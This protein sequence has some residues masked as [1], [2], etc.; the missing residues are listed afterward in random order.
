MKLWLQREKGVII[1]SKKLLRIMKK[2]QLLSV[3]RRKNKYQPSGVAH[4]THPN[5]LNRQFETQRKNKKWVTDITYIQTSQGVLYLSAILDLFDRSIVAYQVSSSP[6][7][8]LV[9]QTLQS[10]WVEEK[11]AGELLLHSDQGA[12]YTSA[13]YQS[14]SKAYGITLSMSRKGNCYDNSVI[15]GFFSILKTEWIY[16]FKPRDF[17]EAKRMIEEYIYFYNNHR[18]QLKSGQTPL[19]RRNLSA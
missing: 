8:E 9:L 7:S 16:R 11:V 2:Y 5:L 13:A 17:C 4:L 19:E 6:T 1:N 18:I 3:I 14:L 10:A 12:Q 15:E